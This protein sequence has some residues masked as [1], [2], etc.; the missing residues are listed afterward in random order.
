[1]KICLLMSCELHVCLVPKDARGQI[2]IPPLELKVYKNVNNL[3]V[4]SPS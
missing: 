1:M 2:Q 4:C 3:F